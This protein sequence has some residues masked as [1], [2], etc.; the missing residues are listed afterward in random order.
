MANLYSIPQFF[1]FKKGIA[2]NLLDRGIASEA[3]NVDT[4]DGALQTIP[5]SINFP[6]RFK[7]VN[8]A[9][10]HAVTQPIIMWRG[11]DGT[12]RYVANNLV[13]GPVAGSAQQIRAF[14]SDEQD[15]L[16]QFC[17]SSDP[18]CF[19]T[20]IGGVP[21]TLLLQ[22]GVRPCVVEDGA[23]LSS[24]C[25]IR[26]FGSGMFLT[27][28]AITAIEMDPVDTSKVLK[29]TITRLMTDDEI[30]RCLY[31]GVYF[32]ANASDTEDFAAAAVSDVAVGSTSTVITLEVPVAGVTVGNYAKVRGGLSDMENHLFAEFYGR[33]FAAGDPD[34]PRRLYW[35]CLPGDGRTVEDWTADDASPDTGGGH[36]EI[37]LEGKIVCLFAMPSQLLIFKERE[38]YRLYGATPSQYTLERVFV[39]E[40]TV[41]YSHRSVASVY[42]TPYWVNAEGLWMYNG[43]SVQ[44]VDGDRSIQSYLR[45]YSLESRFFYQWP[46]AGYSMPKI[47]E[48]WDDRLFFMQPLGRS[49][50]AFD[51]MT[52][53][54]TEIRLDP[55]AYCFD[56]RATDVGLVYSV[57]TDDYTFKESTW[58]LLLFG[59]NSK[60]SLSDVEARGVHNYGPLPNSEVIPIDA[61][62]ESP[63]ITF[64]EPSYRK[65]LRRI[66]FEITGSVKLLVS[67]PE[68]VHY[69]KVL[70]DTTNLYRRMEWLTV[71]MPFETSLRFRFESVD[72]RPFRIHSGIDCYIDF[73]KRN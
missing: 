36:V 3:I 55:H 41:V 35:S 9:T 61:V 28:D 40:S 23:D 46:S 66:G 67:S 19:T 62:W 14:T 50:V 31:A 58:R 65:Q 6:T 44:R 21:S 17:G 29:I 64:G 45:E 49:I 53:A 18:T 52:G 24:A 71:D 27:S 8:N 26:E 10:I 22:E 34:H 73:V 70:L 63:Y 16:E 13:F 12:R 72:G 43:S 32:M 20:M 69:E 25:V 7:D 42:G 33:L 15:L 47:C 2:D 56:M 59:L 4:T 39:S 60:D 30:S 54:S 5:G 51:L 11:P 57:G 48:F 37:G 1:G 38:V 68:D